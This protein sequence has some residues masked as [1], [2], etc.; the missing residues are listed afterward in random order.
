M[1]MI[2]K[3]A[4]GALISVLF[5]IG[6]IAESVPAR[7]AEVSTNSLPQAIIAYGFLRSNYA[8][9]DQLLTSARSSAVVRDINELQQAL[10]SLRCDVPTRLAFPHQDLIVPPVPVGDWIGFQRLTEE[11]MLF[12]TQAVGVNPQRVWVVLSSVA[13]T[14]TTVF[15]FQNSGQGYASSLL[16]DSFNKG[17]VSNAPDTVIGAVV[18]VNLQKNNDILLKEAAEPGSRPG[19]MGAVGKIFQI[20]FIDGNVLLKAAGALPQR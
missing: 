17:D 18:Q 13:P 2:V 9:F 6:C 5:G 14:R 7:S 16:Y 20:N 11:G 1:Q 15:S 12:V 19:R 10:F 8:D 3:L 4:V